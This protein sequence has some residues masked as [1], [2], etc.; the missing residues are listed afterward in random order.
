MQQR[1]I[2][3]PHPIHHHHLPAYCTYSIITA[4][5]CLPLPRIRI[6]GH[7]LYPARE[8]CDGYV[9]AV[10]RFNAWSRVCPE[11]VCMTRTKTRLIHV[12]INPGVK[13]FGYVKCDWGPFSLVIRWASC[14]SLSALGRA[15]AVTTVG[16]C[17]SVYVRGGWLLSHWFCSTNVYALAILR[18]AA[19]ACLLARATWGSSHQILVLR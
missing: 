1:S 19:S 16:P 11:I 18:D 9:V 7:L 2:H 3:Q 8:V 6:S 12:G 13:L 17:Y 10:T 5:G 4:L 15:P 14:A